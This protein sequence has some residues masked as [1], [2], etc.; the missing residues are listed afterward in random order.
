MSTT[1]TRPLRSQNTLRIQTTVNYGIFK[2]VGGNRSINP[3]HVKKLVSSIS[4]RNLMPYNPVLVNEDGYVIDG[5]H[6]IEACKKLGI[7]VHY[8]AIPGTG[9]EE[10]RLL[11]AHLRQ[12]SVRDFAESYAQ[13]GNTHYITLL[14]FID[15]YKTPAMTTAELL[16]GEKIQVGGRTAGKV[17]DGTF[18]VKNVK[19]AELFIARLKDVMPYIDGRPAKNRDFLRA[20]K[21][22]YDKGA[23]H[24]LFVTQLKRAKRIEKQ[25]DYLRWLLAMADC[26]NY[27]QRDK[28][29][30][31]LEP[32]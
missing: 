15:K 25:P 22:F 4:K 9:M 16:A 30:D 29:I 24:E 7:E 23:N 14:A 6:R 26:Y 11:N 1:L 13:E 19:D 31:V 8:I 20:L 12:W 2:T 28:K 18:K 10:I 5:Q 3:T 27:Q 32:S 17:R 21:A